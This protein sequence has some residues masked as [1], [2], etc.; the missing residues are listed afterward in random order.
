MKISQQQI[1]VLFTVLHDVLKPDQQVTNR[2][3][4]YVVT[5]SFKKELLA[6]L[7]NEILK[8]QDTSLEEFF[9]GG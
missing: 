1:M 3:N 9:T 6:D 4:C 7:Y 2:E 8:Q 5:L